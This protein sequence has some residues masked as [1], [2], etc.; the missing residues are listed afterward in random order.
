MKTNTIPWRKTLYVCSNCKDFYNP[1]P[2][3]VEPGDPITI[4]MIQPFTC[5]TCLIMMGRKD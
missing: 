4:D 5:E 2:Y 3:N 1:G